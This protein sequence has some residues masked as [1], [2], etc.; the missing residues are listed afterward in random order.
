MR[1]LLL[2]AVVILICFCSANAQNKQPLTESSVVK[3][4]LGAVV[5]YNIWSSLLITGHY[6]IKADAKVNTEFILYRLSDEEYEKTLGTMP[7]PKE[8]NFFRT[9]SK[10]SHFKTTD[11]NGNK[12]N[13]KNMAGKIIV[14][15]FWF[16]NCPPC[17]QEMPELNKLSD[18]YRSDSSIVF[19]A[20][21]LDKKYD[22]E[23]FLNGSGFGYTIIDN[24]RFITDQYHIN[25]YPTNVVVDQNGKVYFHSTGLNVGTIHWLKK[26]I[27]ELKNSGNKKDATA[28]SE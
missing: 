1:K 10:F 7:K 26:S 8:S 17:R 21:A 12:I 4:T 20:I 22:L 15:N 9:G 3:D 19:L 6:K 16:I 24:G 27:E 23:Q 18:T 28:K 14:L 25:S 2:T 11:I 13:T 5:P